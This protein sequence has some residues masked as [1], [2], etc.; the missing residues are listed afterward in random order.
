MFLWCQYM[1]VFTAL[2][3]TEFTL[4]GIDERWQIIMLSFQICPHSFLQQPHTSDSM[5]MRN[6]HI[7]LGKYVSAERAV[8]PVFVGLHFPFCPSVWVWSC[9]HTLPSQDGTFH[10]SLFALVSGWDMWHYPAFPSGLHSRLLHP[11]PKV[12]VRHLPAGKSGVCQFNTV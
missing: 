11:S 8:R 6:K 3:G 2:H 7:Y 10:S 4:S 1:Q 12:C 5:S 9:Y